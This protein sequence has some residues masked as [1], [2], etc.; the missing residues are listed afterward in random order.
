MLVL[1]VWGPIKIQLT[2]DPEATIFTTKRDTD[3][4]LVIDPEYQNETEDTTKISAKLDQTL[5]ADIQAHKSLFTVSY[6]YNEHI[7]I[8]VLYGDS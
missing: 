3:L 1:Y 8:L 4:Q 5:N 7:I 2:C 6:N